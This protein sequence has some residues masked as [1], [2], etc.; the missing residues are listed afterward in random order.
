M[1]KTLWREAVEASVTAAAV[2]GEHDMVTKCLPHFLGSK[3]EDR[4]DLGEGTT[5]V[6]ALEAQD[7]YSGRQDPDSGGK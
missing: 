1:L 5:V 4:K 7:S 2:K 3:S 6:E